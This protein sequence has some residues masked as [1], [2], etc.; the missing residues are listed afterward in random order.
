[1]AHWS[2]TFG[3]A[4]RDPSAFS[5]GLLG[6]CQV[7]CGLEG[8]GKVT[9][10]LAPVSERAGRPGSRVPADP[11]RV[12]LVVPQRVVRESLATVLDRDPGVRVVVAVADSTELAA[13]APS[14]VDVVVAEPGASR[15]SLGRLRELA[16]A[17][18]VVL[19]AGR[20]DVGLVREAER[21]GMSGLF[22]E[23]STAEELAD[24]A[25]NAARQRGAPVLTWPGAAPAAPRTPAAAVR[26]GRI[27]PAGSDTLTTRER[28]VLATL[29]RERSTEAAA[30]A[31]AISPHTLKTHVKRILSKLGTHSRA[32]ALAKALRLG[33]VSAARL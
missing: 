8:S 20:D 5:D 1:M 23:D 32:E 33:L 17:A 16:G 18:P 27:A 4:E 12:A 29:A 2:G 3:D 13:T 25:R 6:R 21:L 30:E 7:A 9:D 26:S 22:V 10:M 28:E 31:L 24:A 19:L 14:G 11:V 15:R